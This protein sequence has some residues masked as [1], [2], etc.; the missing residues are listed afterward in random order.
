MAGDTVSRSL[1]RALAALVPVV[2]LL[3]GCGDAGTLH[4]KTL[5]GEKTGAIAILIDTPV[6]PA[7][8][9][10]MDVYLKGRRRGI[11][12]GAGGPDQ[13]AT[14]VKR[15]EPT[16]VV[17][18]PPGPAL[19]RIRDELA[20]PPQ[21]F[22][23]TTA[24]TFWVAPVTDR[25]LGFARFLTSRKGKALLTSAPCALQNTREF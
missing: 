8:R 10:T 5:V 23:V 18:M 19:D 2:A 1:R 9:C 25:G 4:A 15:G 12:Y 22:L 24:A 14:A 13:I 17:I 20:S 16:D 3:T 6:A 7:I 11:K 21:P